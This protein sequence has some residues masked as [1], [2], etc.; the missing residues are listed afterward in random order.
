[1]GNKLNSH[2]LGKAFTEQRHFELGLVPPK[3]HFPYSVVIRP[4]PRGEF[5]KTVVVS[6][7]AQA[8]HKMEATCLDPK[9]HCTLE[10]TL[11]GL[12]VRVRVVDN[13]TLPSIQSSLARDDA[14]LPGSEG[15]P[16]DDMVVL[17]VGPG[18]AGLSRGWTPD[19]HH[20]F[21]ANRADCSVRWIKR[22]RRRRWIKAQQPFAAVVQRPRIKFSPREPR[23]RQVT[24]KVLLWSAKGQV[25]IGSKFPIT[26]RE[27]LLC[28]CKGKRREK[29][30]E[31][32]VDAKIK[33]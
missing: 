29:I 33:I 25:D 14:L 1:M 24:V 16:V 22:R 18:K 3:C 20:N 12:W 26:A 7:M 13:N 9:L 5:S 30:L 15:V 21:L 2:H 6:G 17:H 10:V 8:G 31:H 32:A 23:A 27:I 11:A 19:K 28:P 4:T